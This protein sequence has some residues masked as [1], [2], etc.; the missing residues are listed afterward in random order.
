MPFTVRSSR[1]RPIGS[2]TPRER[3]C[4]S[5]CVFLR[6]QCSGVTKDP[7]CQN[8]SNFEY[9]L[10]KITAHMIIRLIRS[11]TRTLMYRVYNVRD[12]L[13]LNFNILN[14]SQTLLCTWK[15]AQGSWDPIGRHPSVNGNFAQNLL[16]ILRIKFRQSGPFGITRALLLNENTPALYIIV[17]SLVVE[18]LHWNSKIRRTFRIHSHPVIYGSVRAVPMV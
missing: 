9:I 7:D 12:F 18:K 4:Q 8:L 16:K 13:D 6:L 14:F 5:G 17:E 15:L 10:S 1:C 2:R 11:H 3:L